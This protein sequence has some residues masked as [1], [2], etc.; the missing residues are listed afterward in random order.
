MPL[1]ILSL[2]LELLREITTYLDLQD[3][4]S[5]T[6]ASVSLSK[7]LGS[8]ST[9]KEIAIV[10]PLL[11]NKAVNGANLVDALQRCIPFSKEADLARSGRTTYRAALSGACRRRRAYASAQPASALIIGRGSDFLH[12]DGTLC[13]LREGAVHVLNIHDAASTELVIEF[14]SRLRTTASSSVFRLLH[15]Q[16]NV[17]SIS[18]T[19]QS[20]AGSDG[21]V[22]VFDT[23]P[24][25]LDHLRL[26]I[27]KKLPTGHR[28]F[29][30]HDSRYLVYGSC[31]GS[32]GSDDDIWRFWKFDLARGNRSLK[33]FSPGGFTTVDIGS[34]VVFEI[35]DGY[36]Y[37]LTSQITVDA[38]G[39]DPS[40]YYGGS[41]YLLE[42]DEAK[43]E[44]WRIWRRQQREGPIHDLWTD[45]ALERDEST[46]QLMIRESRREWQDGF[47]KQS[48]T[49]YTQ[50]L[51]F[52]P[53]KDPDFIPDPTSSNY[54]AQIAA[55]PCKEASD[56]FDGTIESM[57]SEPETEMIP[58]LAEPQQRQRQ[59][60]H[61]EYGNSQRPPGTREFTVTNTKHRTYNV[62]SSAF[63]DVVLDEANHIRFRIG[64]RKPASPL[65]STKISEELYVDN[66]IKLW[67]PEVASSNLINLLNP[68]TGPP[69]D[70]KVMSDERSVVYMSTGK[71]P[72]SSIILV[73][74]DPAIRFPGLKT[75]RQGD[76]GLETERSYQDVAVV[77]GAATWAREQ[78]AWWEINKIGYQF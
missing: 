74:F 35:I 10:S 11:H 69:R 78:P 46:G 49:F 33:S 30:R 38:E 27:C 56:T 41:R 62:S 42:D 45:L 34:T 66:G 26:L 5:L 63:L 52:P 14:Q 48:R 54:Y 12:R 19:P 29:V 60:C 36:L 39:H 76:I 59:Y 15:Y 18:C 20:D 50:P 65:I 9:C 25:T 43:P 6:E 40:S 17:V 23:K 61:S 64:S 1:D 16:N 67:P 28:Q 53:H 57:L 68:T 8:E 24:N 21:Y 71:E 22:I 75:W 70:V 4:C 31:S 58:C 51:L 7:V 37:V 72:L 32:G 2:P 13:Y 44:I 3:Y 77:R 47:S 55:S 73:N